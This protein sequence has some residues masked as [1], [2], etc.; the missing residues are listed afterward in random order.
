MSLMSLVS[1]TKSL[2]DAHLWLLF[3]AGQS[4]FKEVSRGCA[5]A[6][7][8]LVTP[9]QVSHRCSGQTIQFSGSQCPDDFVRH[10]VAGSV[11]PDMFGGASQ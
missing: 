2:W 8:A 4:P 5:N 3:A 7:T 9:K 1:Q 6:V 10:C 11:A